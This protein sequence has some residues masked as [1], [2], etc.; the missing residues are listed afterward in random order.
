MEYQCRSAPK[1][2]RP[3]ERKI[4]ITDQLKFNEELLP[5]QPAT[6]HPLA[7]G[8]KVPNLFEFTPE[9]EL[10]MYETRLVNNQLLDEENLHEN[11]SRRGRLGAAIKGLPRTL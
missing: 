10:F 8:T 6:A 3:E 9:T 4:Y 7:V 2:W 5:L 1:F 11:G